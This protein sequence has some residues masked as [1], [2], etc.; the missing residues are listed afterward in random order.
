MVY[1]PGTILVKREAFRK[2]IPSN[3]IYE[4]R[5]GQNYQLML[6]LAYCGKCGYL[7]MALAKYVIHPDSHSKRTRSFAEHVARQREFIVL[8]R[9][10]LERIPGMTETDYT[11]Y[12][13]IA[14]EQLLNTE[15]CYSLQYGHFCHYWKV[16]GELKK[17]DLQ[18]QRRARCIIYYGRKIKR[19]ARDY[20]K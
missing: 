13:K 10:T 12:M 11:R 15:L 19:F 6:P 17:K 3:A 14:Y 20:I 7:D 16:R 2:A 1:G 9:E 18:L 4:S 5:Q 8:V